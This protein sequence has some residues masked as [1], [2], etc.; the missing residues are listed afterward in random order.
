[1]QNNYPSKPWK[2]QIVMIQYF[3]DKLE[4]NMNE[5]Q[6]ENSY[7]LSYDG[8]NRSIFYSLCN[9]IKIDFI[10]W[11]FEN[12]FNYDKDD[13]MLQRRTHHEVHPSRSIIL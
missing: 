9:S 5:N 12:N 3:N 8:P 6:F 13:I 1:M 2:K 11:I 7:P 10:N 4:N